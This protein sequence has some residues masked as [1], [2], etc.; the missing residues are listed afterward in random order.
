MNLRLG[1][2]GARRRIPLE[3]PEW[4]GVEAFLPGHVLTGRDEGRLLDLYDLTHFAKVVR[5]HSVSVAQFARIHPI[6]A[7]PDGEDAGAEYSNYSNL[8]SRLVS[9]A[10]AIGLEV[11]AS[12]PDRG[13]S[14][15]MSRAVGRRRTKGRA[16]A[17]REERLVRT[18][19]SVQVRIVFK[20]PWHACARVSELL[21]ALAARAPWL[22]DES[23]AAQEVTGADHEVEVAHHDA[24]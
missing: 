9:F 2:R 15:C 23:D 12:S 1:R 3:A 13:S 24:P 11:S 4:H 17:W 20:N 14:R 6:K 5:D 21:D 10:Q 7:R 16:G 18:A 8:V 22:D 19:E